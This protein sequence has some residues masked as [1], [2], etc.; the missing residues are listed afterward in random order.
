ML[1]R[2]AHT[3]EDHGEGLDDDGS[4]EASTA[5]IKLGLIHSLGY[6]CQIDDKSV[7]LS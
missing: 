5:K 6:F 3:P 4:L 2:M 1:E 7:V